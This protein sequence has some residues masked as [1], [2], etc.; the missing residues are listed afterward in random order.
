NLY[1]KHSS[2]KGKIPLQDYSSSAIDANA[3][4][5]PGN[6][7][8]WDVRFGGLQEVYNKYGFEPK[9]ISFPEDST[10]VKFQTWRGRLSFHNINK[11]EFGLSYAPEMKI[12]VFNDQLSNSESNTYFNLPLQKAIG[13]EFA[14]DFDLTANLSRYKPDGKAA[15]ANNYFSFS[16]S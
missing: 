5:K 6:N 15:I 2:S 9:S 11:T 7:M 14:I 12:D 4:F 16:P 13:K 3:Y 8:E 10:D 1:A